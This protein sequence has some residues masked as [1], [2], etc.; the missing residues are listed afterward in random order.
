MAIARGPSNKLETK[1]SVP[2]NASV[3]ILTGHIALT[4]GR[5]LHS[6]ISKRPQRQKY[7]Q[8]CACALLDCELLLLLKQKLFYP[9]VFIFPSFCPQDEEAPVNMILR[10]ECLSKIDSE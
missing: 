10:G 4:S 9:W 2:S 8:A 7:V 5:V 6:Y 1:L 3:L